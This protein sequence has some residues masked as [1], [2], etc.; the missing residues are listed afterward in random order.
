MEPM[1]TLVDDALE[2]VHQQFDGR[3]P[4]KEFNDRIKQMDA[5]TLRKMLLISANQ[6]GTLLKGGDYES[7][8][9]AAVHVSAGADIIITAYDIA[10]MANIATTCEEGN[11]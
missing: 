6:V 5:N 8:G 10:S 7:T 2:E 3:D 9:D 4:I 11:A 1:T